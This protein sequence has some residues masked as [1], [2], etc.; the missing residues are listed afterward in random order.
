MP[1]RIVDRF[2]P[3]QVEHQYREIRAIASGLSQGLLDPFTEQNAVWQAGQGVM[4]SHEHDLR[5][6][7]PAFGDVFERR[8]P[9]T[10]G[11]RPA[12]HGD[13]PAVTD[14]DD[15]RVI[16][17]L[18]LSVLGIQWGHP[19]GGYAERVDEA[20]ARVIA[21]LHAHRQYLSKGQSWDNCGG[22]KVEDFAKATIDD[23]EALVGIVQAKAL[24]HVVQRGIE[25]EIGC[26]QPY[27]LVAQ[28]GDVAENSDEAPIAGGAAADAQP[29]AIEQPHLAS[30]VRSPGQAM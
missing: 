22:R 30:V 28:G 16:E 1:Q 3:V 18:E 19:S 12:G 29:T 4:L 2:E 26:L 23:F 10:I 20:F 27:R 5:L 13:Q 21:G 7:A 14:L 15:P 17:L 6:G 8:N 24:R 9:T 11:H 25:A